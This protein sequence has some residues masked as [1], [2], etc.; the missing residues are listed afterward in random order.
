MCKIF[1]STWYIGIQHILLLVSRQVMSV[2]LWLQWLQHAGLPCPSVSLRICSN[3]C[4]LSR[5]CHP[6]ISASFAP[7]LLLPSVFPS[8]RV[9][10]NELAVCIKWPKYWSFGFSIHPSNEYLGLISFRTDWF[11][12]LAVQG[13]LKVFSS[14]TI[15]KYQ[16]FSVQP[17]L[18]S[19]SHIHT[20]LLEKPYFDYM[21]HCWQSNDCAF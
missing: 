6:T 7:V 21:D 2:S 11:D 4:P 1:K 3:S 5:W 19:S 8:I 16:F 12:L 10:S 15:R 14:I 17:F 13:T 18:W 9:F 20:W